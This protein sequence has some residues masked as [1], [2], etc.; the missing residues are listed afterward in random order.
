M[1]NKRDDDRADEIEPAPWDERPVIGT[2][3][4]LP[5]WQAMLLAFGLALF[6]A[7]V[8]L[9]FND[10]LTWLFRGAYF[11][12][13]VAA[14]CWVQRGS[15]FAPM[16]QPPLVLAAIVPTVMVFG[17]SAQSSG[18]GLKDILFGYG[19]PLIND[20]PVMGFTTA[21]TLLAGFARM[22]FQRDPDRVPGEGG[23]HLPLPSLD[24]LGK[25]GRFRRRD[26]DVDPAEETT[27]AAPPRG[28]RPTRDSEPGGAPPRRPAPGAPR[29]A[30]ANHEQV[31]VREP[32]EPPPA[33]RPAAPAGSSGPTQRPPRTP[34]PERRPSQGTR[35]REPV[36][37]AR[38]PPA[39][40]QD[41]PRRAQPKPPQGPPPSSAQPPRRRPDQPQQPGEPPRTPRR[42]P[43]PPRRKPWDPERG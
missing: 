25:F 41:A 31:R 7:V 30:D 38:R 33:R 19:M 21:A 5:W 15:L 40:G 23:T 32:V 17:S 37:P 14:V 36:D 9:Q 24:M 34:P 13:C 10:S 28:Q 22:Y 43:P 42:Q 11:V 35:R 16:V 6:I 18:S 27:I 1:F 4:G 3:H 20:F 8:D 12:G 39:E 2:S 29:Q 26:D